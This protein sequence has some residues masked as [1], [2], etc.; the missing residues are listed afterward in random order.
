[1]HAGAMRGFSLMELVTA[2]VVLAVGIIGVMALYLDRVHEQTRDPHAIAAAL[3]E[4]MAARVRGGG[5][6]NPAAPSTFC[7]ETPDDEDDVGTA[8]SLAREAA[9]WQE[10]VSHALPNG[11]GMV[12]HEEGSSGYRITV[13]WSEAG[14]GAASFVMTVQKS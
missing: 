14:V 10:K 2:I 11:V 4:E 3:A 5:K 9:C 12:E 7:S 8:D 13:S 1:M 6:S